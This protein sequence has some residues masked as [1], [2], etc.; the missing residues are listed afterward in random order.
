MVDTFHA[1]VS[2]VIG[3]RR[4]LMYPWQLVY[5]RRQSSAE[6]RSIIGRRVDGH[7]HRGMKRF[8]RMFAVPSAVGSAVVTA[9]MSARR[10]K[11]SVKRRMYEFPR[12][13]IGRGPK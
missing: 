3:A 12:A 2:T 10:L 5:G 8:T 11:R 6:L 1:S 9:N 7:P 4:E 13:V